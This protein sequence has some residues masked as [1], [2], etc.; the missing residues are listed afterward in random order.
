VAADFPLDRTTG[1]S[2]YPFGLRRSLTGGL[3]SLGVQML[4]PARALASWAGR[5]WAESV[6]RVWPVTHFFYRKYLC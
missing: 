2:P 4:A 5:R 1:I 3:H 6:G